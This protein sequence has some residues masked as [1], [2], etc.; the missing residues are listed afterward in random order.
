MGGWVSGL[1][2]PF[3]WGHF[4]YLRECGDEVYGLWTFDLSLCSGYTSK[5]ASYSK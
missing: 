1:F 3:L 5:L 4:N 2:G